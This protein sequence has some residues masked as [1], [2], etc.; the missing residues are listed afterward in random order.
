MSHFHQTTILPFRYCPWLHLRLSVCVFVCAQ[1]NQ[2]CR[3]FPL[4]Y[5]SR[6][7]HGSSY[8]TVS[9]ISRYTDVGRRGYWTFN[10]IVVILMNFV[11]HFVESSTSS[12]ITAPITVEEWEWFHNE[13]HLSS[14]VFLFSRWAGIRD[15]HMGMQA[16]REHIMK[17]APSA[18]NNIAT[19]DCVI[20][21]DVSMI[22]ANILDQVIYS[23]NTVWS[24]KYKIKEVFQYCVSV[25]V[26]EM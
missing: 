9:I 12:T 5:I 17:H 18:R 8:F 4:T 20:I 21:D 13:F 22:S 3:S 10:I 7:L 11:R 24:F 26:T 1:F 25:T 19:A 14:N 6:P 2:K 23:C 15:G 16:L